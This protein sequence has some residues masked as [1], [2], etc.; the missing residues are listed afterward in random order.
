V[1]LCYLSDDPQG[2]LMMKYKFHYLVR[3]MP[4]ITMYFGIVPQTVKDSFITVDINICRFIYLLCSIGL[5]CLK[6]R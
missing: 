5:S 4:P 2:S 3:K 6:F 1:G